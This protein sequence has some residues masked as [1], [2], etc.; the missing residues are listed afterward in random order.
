MLIVLVGFPLTKADKHDEIHAK[1]Y[2]EDEPVVVTSNLSVLDIEHL[3]ADVKLIIF[4]KGKVIEDPLGVDHVM[5][6]F[7]SSGNS[8]MLEEL[9]RLHGMCV[10]PDLLYTIQDKFPD[11]YFHTFEYIEYRLY[12]LNNNEHASTYGLPPTSKE[13]NA[14]DASTI[15]L[16]AG[17]AIRTRKLTC[18][19]IQ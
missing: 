11:A 5:N 13:I 10:N 14:R 1:L 7:R 8:K 2:L 4:S 18:S 19:N 9:I 3:T 6:T 15:R 16:G 17:E 12:S